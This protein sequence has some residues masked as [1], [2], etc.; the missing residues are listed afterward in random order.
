MT[1]YFDSIQ[2]Y[3]SINPVRNRDCQWAVVFCCCLSSR[4]NTRRHSYSRTLSLLASDSDSLSAPWRRMM[5]M[6]R[7]PNTVAD[8]SFLDFPLLRLLLFLL[9]LSAFHISAFRRH[10]CRSW[11]F[12]RYGAAG[13]SISSSFQSGDLPAEDALQQT[14]EHFHRTTLRGGIT[15]GK[16]MT[17]SHA[18]RDWSECPSYIIRRI[19]PCLQIGGRRTILGFFWRRNLSQLL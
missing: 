8:P 14:N 11:G 19:R 3:Q 17:R 13:R 2:K 1:P 4:Q 12:H 5:R 10:H 9:M 18:V 16:Q 7:R 6:S 15:N